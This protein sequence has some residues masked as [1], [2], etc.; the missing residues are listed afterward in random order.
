MCS[1][2]VLQVGGWAWCCLHPVKSFLLRNLKE[3]A[4]D[5]QGLYSPEEGG[6]GKQQIKMSQMK[7]L[8]P[9]QVYADTQQLSVL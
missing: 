2:L 3:A 4:T 5:L 8:N 6:G 7:G 1:P 9:S